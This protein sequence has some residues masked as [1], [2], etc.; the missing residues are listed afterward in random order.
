MLSLQSVK[1][2]SGVCSITSRS[3]NSSFR[4]LLNFLPAYE[5]AALMHKRTEVKGHGNLCFE[6]F[7]LSFTVAVCV[8][9]KDFLQIL[10]FLKGVIFCQRYVVEMELVFVE[11]CWSLLK[12]SFVL[13]DDLFIY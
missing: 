1:A 12:F 6:E 11:M 9:G 7:R 5:L 8:M 4:L 10:S 3:I 13:E 2:H